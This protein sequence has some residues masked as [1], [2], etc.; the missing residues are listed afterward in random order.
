MATR[1][2]TLSE[3]LWHLLVVLRASSPLRSD[4]PNIL[5]IRI[6]YFFLAAWAI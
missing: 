4:Q 1:V 3:W 5:L 6:G 2:T